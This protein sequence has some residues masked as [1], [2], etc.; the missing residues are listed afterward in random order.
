MFFNITAEELKR[1]QQMRFVKRFLGPP[2][3]PA[4]ACGK[5]LY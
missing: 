4:V 2:N 1:E 3:C 5:L